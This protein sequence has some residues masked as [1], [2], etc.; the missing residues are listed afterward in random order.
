MGYSTAKVGKNRF[1]WAGTVVNFK[2]RCPK[3]RSIT[4]PRRRHRHQVGTLLPARVVNAGFDSAAI[5]RAMGGRCPV[6]WTPAR[7]G[8]PYVDLIRFTTSQEDPRS[9]GGAIHGAPR[10][11]E[12]RN[13]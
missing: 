11:G 6:G 1:V 4:L 2:A 8:K 3:V 7:T 10:W 5:W 9:H 13:H 12:T